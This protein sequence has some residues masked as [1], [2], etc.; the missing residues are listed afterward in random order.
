MSGKRIEELYAWVIFDP[1]EGDEGV[2][3][4]LTM[5]DG[6]MLPLMGA[7]RDRI[8]SLRP[9]AQAASRTVGQ[10]CELRRWHGPYEVIDVV[11][12]A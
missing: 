7:D 5:G 10:K 3:A 2:P 4:T 8:E 1:A 6:I 9:F 11:G 12:G